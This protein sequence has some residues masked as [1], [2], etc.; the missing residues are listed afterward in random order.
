MANDP[1][2]WVFALLSVLGLVAMAIIENK[3]QNEI[4]PKKVKIAWVEDRPII[5]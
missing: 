2:V 3:S 5:I 1:I 4:S